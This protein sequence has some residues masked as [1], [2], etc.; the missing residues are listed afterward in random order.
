MLAVLVFGFTAV[1]NDL[2]GVNYYPS[3]HAWERM[4]LVWDSAVIGKELALARDLGLNAV[5]TY[6]HFPAV[7]PTRSG[8]VNSRTLDRMADFVALADGAGLGVVF[9]LFDLVPD[10][11]FEHWPEQVEYLDSVIGRFK[12]DRRIC[13]WGIRNEINVFTGE[14]SATVVWAESVIARIR[15]VDTIHP[16]EVE[17]TAGGRRGLE[18]SRFVKTLRNKVDVFALSYYG[19]PESLP[20]LIGGLKSDSG[21]ALVVSEFGFPTSD[22]GGEERQAAVFDSML[23]VLREIKLG[24][25]FWTLMDFTEAAVPARERTFGVI[26]ADYS[27][28]PATQVLRRYLR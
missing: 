21:P 14:E 11:S 15:R 4:W 5:E 20:S 19:P 13:L 26:R 6:V 8:G 3:R 28:K 10:H 27:M 16:I 7:M 17:L 1:V 9:T 23:R 24:F 25:R 2:H 12:A 22:E 18:A